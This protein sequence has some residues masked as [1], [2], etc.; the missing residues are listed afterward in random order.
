M[1]TVSRGAVKKV[2][3]TYKRELEN[4]GE[5]VACMKVALE[6]LLDKVNEGR[7]Y[8]RPVCAACQV[9]M[10]PERNGVGILDMADY[11]PVDLWNADLWEC[12]KCGHQIVSGFG[13]NPISSHYKK[14]EFPRLI[15]SYQDRSIIIESR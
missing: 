13:A 2:L 4:D 7:G 8:H 10:Y 6:E 12:P 3:F 11:G 9:E 15:K 1:A 14:D 5:E